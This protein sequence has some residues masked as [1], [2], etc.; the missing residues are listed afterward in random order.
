MGASDAIIWAGGSA[1]SRLAAIVRDAG[2]TLVAAGGPNPEAVRESLNNDDVRVFDDL[3]A[4]VMAEKPSVVLIA[5]FPDSETG[6]LDGRTLAELRASGTAVL[7]TVSPATGLIQAGESGL[8]K[9]TGGTSP[10]AG[11]RLVPRVRRQP[12]FRAAE[13]AFSDFG[14]A[15]LITIES[16]APPGV[17]GA[18]AAMLGALDTV[19]TLVG[20][21][22][23]VDAAA[24]RPTKRL[25]ELEG[26]A[27]A[28]LRFA[29]G[30]CGQLLISDRAPWGWR[31]TLSGASGR[32]TVRPSGFDWVDAEGKK[33]DS[34]RTDGPNAGFEGVV[35][36]AVRGAID[37][38]HAGEPAT[39]WVGL[40]STAEA[41]L[42]SS[43]TG[44][45][46]SPQ[47]IARAAAQPGV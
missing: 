22:E 46:E 37:G 12:S 4:T 18:A 16:F 19:Q 40:L 36:E 20:Q 6:S 42:L 33:Q 3:R 8:F 30:R 24:A 47:T 10:A 39:D 26:S 38:S 44:E 31:I 5:A 23:L 7:T 34:T 35:A 29:D 17:G 41:V 15:N 43:R 14:Q 28:L 2:A 13:D 32:F 25:S 9:E 21:P 45:P 11:I 1:A 27:A